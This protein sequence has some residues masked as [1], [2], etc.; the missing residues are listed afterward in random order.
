MGVL[1]SE[2]L[3]SAWH[4]KRWY[5][6]LALKAEEDLEEVWGTSVSIS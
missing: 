3:G 4:G 5:L 6:S 2:G 1:R